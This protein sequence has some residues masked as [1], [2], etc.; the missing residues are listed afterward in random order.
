[1][2]P[3]RLLDITYNTTSD[4]F[5]STVQ[6][7]P[8]EAN[9]TP[10]EFY[11]KGSWYL[12]SLI[13][14][15]IAGLLCVAFLYQCLQTFRYS[16]HIYRI[17]R[18]GIIVD[19]AINQKY[20]EEDE[21]G[22]SYEYYIGYKYRVEKKTIR[23]RTQIEENVYHHTEIGDIVKIKYDPHDPSQSILMNKS[24]NK[25]KICR[26]F[27]YLLILILLAMAICFWIFWQS[28]HLNHLIEGMILGFSI[29]LFCIIAAFMGYCIEQKIFCFA[30]I[31]IDDDEDENKS[32]NVQ[33]NNNK[34]SSKRK[35]Y[36]HHHHNKAN[37]RP[38]KSSNIELNMKPEQDILN[39]WEIKKYTNRSDIN[40]KHSNMNQNEV[41]Y[42][43]LTK[44]ALFIYLRCNCKINKTDFNA[45][46]GEF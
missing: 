23:S 4:Q 9:N 1:M 28:N 3:P 34:L 10:S 8:D 45:E 36:I 14:G 31:C 6:L 38:R 7:F 44:F 29:V 20:L 13:L 25:Y 33:R 5:N 16:N 22:N 40:I 32:E 37:K 26:Q 39:R 12:W 17:Y 42:G 21:T 43:M 30:T 24:R 18:N 41:S 15:V 11:D 19:A 2:A 27:V 35:M 46:F